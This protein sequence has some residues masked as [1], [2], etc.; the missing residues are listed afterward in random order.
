MVYTF[1]HHGRFMVNSPR[2]KYTG[3][4]KNASDMCHVHSMSMLEMYDITEELGYN[5]MFNLYW[6]QLDVKLIVKPLRIDS[7]VIKIEEYDA[8]E[9]DED[10]VV[11]EVEQTKS[12]SGFEDNDKDM[13]DE[14]QVQE[15]DY[16]VLMM[17]LE[18]GKERNDNASHLNECDSGSDSLHSLSEN[19]FD[20]D[21]KKKH[22]KCPKFNTKVDMSNPQFKKWMKFSGKKIMEEAI[23]EYV[24]RSMHDV[25]FKRVDKGRMHVSLSKCLRDKNL[26][27]ETVLGNHKAQY[28]KIYDYLAEIRTSNPGNTKILQTR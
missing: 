23:R 22:P 5:G 14:V 3:K 25:R 10:Y 18:F 7:D 28:S 19:E 26:A 6:K 1:V 27:L 13:N 4:K 24:I 16:E 8:V 2:L 15:V 21:D 20:E 9:E 11:D 17:E 12:D